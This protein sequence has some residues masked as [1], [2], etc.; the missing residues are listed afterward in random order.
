MFKKLKK[1]MLHPNQYFYDYFRKKLEFKKY[2]VTDKIKLLD[3]GNHRKWVKLL[4]SHPNLYLYYKFNKRLRKPAYPILVNYQIRIIQENFIGLDRGKSKVLVVELENRNIIYFA[5]PEIVLKALDNS[6]PDLSKFIFKFIFHGQ[7]NKVFIDAGVHFDQGFNVNIEG[8]CN[9]IYL[10]YESVFHSNSLISIRG[11]SNTIRIGPYC[12]YWQHVHI[13]LLGCCNTIETR[14]NITLC[15]NTVIVHKENNNYSYFGPHSY[16][17]ANSNLCLNGGNA[18]LYISDYVS[19]GTSNIQIG[20]GS[21]FFVGIKSTAGDNFRCFL[22]G[23]KNIIIGAACL[24]HKNVHLE[25]EFSE[26]I[27]GADTS[28]RIYKSDSIL[29]GDHVCVSMNSYILNGSIIG[30]GSLIGIGAVV[31]ENIPDRCLAMGAPAVIKHKNILWKYD[32]QKIEIVYKQKICEDL[33]DIKEIGF[34]KLEEI[35]R[36]ATDLDANKKINIIN[37]II[38]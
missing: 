13:L 26:A 30:S 33:N 10:G 22:F 38:K 28:E 29:L 27:Y 32:S 17:S 34:D 3:A 36:I 15:Q 37:Q 14:N 1:L 9:R 2:F 7:E 6:E 4:F 16:V 5:E 21:I 35:D 31:T 18:I 11:N 20:S 8:S 23:E 19:F 12:R 24:I 25:N